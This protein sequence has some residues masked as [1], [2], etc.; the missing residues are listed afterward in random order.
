[1][2]RCCRAR[3]RA[4]IVVVGAGQARNRHG[5][6]GAE[7]PAVRA[8]HRHRHG[9]DQ[10]RRQKRAGATATATATAMATATA[11]IAPLRRRRTRRPAAQ[12][13]PGGGW[14][15]RRAALQVALDLVQVPW[16][17]RFLR[18]EPLPDGVLP[19]LV[20]AVDDGEPTRPRGDRPPR[21]H[22][23]AA[24]F[25]IEQV[26]LSPGRQ[27][28][29]ARRRPQRRRA[30]SGATW[31][32]SCGG[33]IRTWTAKATPSVFVGRD[34]RVEQS[35]DAGS[36]RGLRPGAA[37]RG[38]AGQYA[39]LRGGGEGAL[40]PRAS[41]R[42]VR[43]AQGPP[44]PSAGVLAAGQI[45]VL[46]RR[47]AAARPR[48]P[49]CCRGHVRC[50]GFLQL[51]RAIGL[52]AAGAVLAW[53][54]VSRDSGGVPRRQCAAGR[55]VAQSGR[56]PGAPEPRRGPLRSGCRHRAR[57]G[58]RHGPCLGRGGAGRRSGRCPRLAHPGPGGACG[59]RRGRGPGL[60]WGPQAAARCRTAGRRIGC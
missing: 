13:A 44:A 49:A 36:P 48:R 60:S 28:S 14:W 21:A 59:R 43:Q 52:A 29:R 18:S 30:S 20:A 55:P 25:F 26:L 9:A 42:G 22:A 1:M 10:V 27:L 46:M 11:P 5:A 19:V 4:T 12:R 51:L 56:P 37:E 31:R 15:R 8:R 41:L 50:R 35:Q 45:E 57:G 6:Q 34:R 24:T 40:G 39:V 47:R 58:P 54:V 32:C 53:L 33:C 38:D 17:V 16:R 23:H 2:H 3:R 7:A